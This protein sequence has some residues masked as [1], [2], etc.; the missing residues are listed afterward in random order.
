MYDGLLLGKAEKDQGKKN[1]PQENCGSKM[2]RT[3]FIGKREQCHLR[4]NM[5]E[6]CFRSG[7]TSEW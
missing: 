4:R 6:K 7:G 5:C 1:S 3:L 2:M